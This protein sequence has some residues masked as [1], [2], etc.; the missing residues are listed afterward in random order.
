[1]PNDSTEEQTPSTQPP[2][3]KAPP[4]EEVCLAAINRWVKRLPSHR[5][6]AVLSYVLSA[7]PA[8]VAG[9][10]Q[11]IPGSDGGLSF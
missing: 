7:Q 10:Q 11:T 6:R 2:S 3:E 4:S 1:M 9:P 8:M 5:R